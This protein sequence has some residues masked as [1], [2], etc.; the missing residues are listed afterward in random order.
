MW[1]ERTGAPEREGARERESAHTRAVYSFKK[2]CSREAEQ[3]RLRVTTFTS[4]L[5]VCIF[6][7][8]LNIYAEVL[9]IVPDHSGRVSSTTKVR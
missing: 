6:R 9:E 8:L 2:I 7:E 5:C 1:G 3:T 4:T